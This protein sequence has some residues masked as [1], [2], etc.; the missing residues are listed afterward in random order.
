[1]FQEEEGRKR[2]EDRKD[3]EELTGH[4]Y[5]QR[6]EGKNLEWK[7][8]EYHSGAH[9]SS[10]NF[11]LQ[12]SSYTSK[13]VV[14]NRNP[15]QQP[16]TF[17]LKPYFPGPIWLLFKIWNTTKI[18]S[19]DSRSRISQVK[20]RHWRGFVYIFLFKLLFKQPLGLGGGEQP[21][22]STIS[23]LHSENVRDFPA[24]PGLLS[25]GDTGSRRNLQVK[26]GAQNFKVKG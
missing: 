20:N 15:I 14:T 24:W 18:I 23:P 7:R 26:R 1:M 8:P 9:G 12:R 2:Q 22:S 3:I 13:K 11:Y 21:S 16:F 6:K 17:D 25:C 4:I 10:D 5:I 19:T